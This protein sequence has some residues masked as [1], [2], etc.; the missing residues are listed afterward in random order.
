MQSTAIRISVI[1]I[2]SA[3]YEL[4]RKTNWLFVGFGFKHFAAAIEPCGANM[5]TQMQLSGRRLDSRRGRRQEIVRTTHIA[6]G[7]AFFV[8]LNSHGNS[9]KRV[10]I[11]RD[12]S[13][14]LILMNSI[15]F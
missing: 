10:A 6:P 4:D 2:K 5:M 1:G 14:K 7:R 12:G 11:V 13:R 3:I 8:L 9:W 15:L